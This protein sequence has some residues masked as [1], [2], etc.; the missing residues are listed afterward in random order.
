MSQ[1]LM[2]TPQSVLICVEF[3]SFK[4]PATKGPPY[5]LQEKVYVAHLSHPGEKLPYDDDLDLEEGK[6]SSER[7]EGALVRLARWQ[8]ERTHEVGAGTDWVSIWSHPSK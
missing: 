1:L 2:P 8:P 5:G 7:G 6:V 4:P 3:P